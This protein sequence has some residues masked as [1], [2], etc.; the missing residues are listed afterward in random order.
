MKEKYI[1]I[2]NLYTYTNDFDF[3]VK[4]KKQIKIIR[5]NVETAYNYVKL[6]HPTTKGYVELLNSCSVS[7]YEQNKK[8]WAEYLAK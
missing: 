4:S 8:S 2:F 3:I 7:R 5:T 6:K 1:F